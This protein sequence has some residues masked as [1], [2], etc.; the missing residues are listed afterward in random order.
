MIPTSPS[1]GAGGVLHD[2]QSMSPMAN[3]KQ[4]VAGNTLGFLF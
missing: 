4:A 3:E 2:E 1:S